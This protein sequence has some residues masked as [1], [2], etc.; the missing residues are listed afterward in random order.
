[1]RYETSPYTGGFSR[2]TPQIPPRHLLLPLPPVARRHVDGAH[3]AL[4]QAPVIDIV[5]VRVTARDRQR[6]DAAVLAEH[7]LGRFRAEAVDLNVFFAGEGFE[8]GFVDDETLEACGGG[9]M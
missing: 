1:M 6:R 5:T 2:R 7:V 3:G 4:V 8:G 9:E